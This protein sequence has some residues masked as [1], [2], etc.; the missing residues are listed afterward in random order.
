MRFAA[1]S[2]LWKGVEADFLGLLRL[3]KTTAHFG[4]FTFY[5]KLVQCLSVLF[6]TSVDR[7]IFSQT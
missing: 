5:A 3:K 6:Y 1:H 4:P 7:P 2:L